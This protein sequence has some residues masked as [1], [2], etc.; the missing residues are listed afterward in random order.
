MS[1]FHEA[2]PQ[3]QG[4]T[5]SKKPQLSRS[6]QSVLISALKVPNPSVQGKLEQLVTLSLP[7]PL[8]PVPP[9]SSSLRNNP[10][11]NN[12]VRPVGAWSQLTRFWKAQEGRGNSDPAMVGQCLREPRVPGDRNDILGSEAQAS[13]RLPRGWQMWCVVPDFSALIPL[14]VLRY[15]D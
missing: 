1:P 11:R 12:P 7:L 14:C 2:P 6:A 9:P 15:G 8:L 3:R 13:P 4:E 10:V 5:N